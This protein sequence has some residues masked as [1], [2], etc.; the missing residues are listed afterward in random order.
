MRGRDR[1][2]FRSKFDFFC[3]PGVVEVLVLPVKKK[4]P[5]KFGG[6]RVMNHSKTH[7]TANSDIMPI[8]KKVKIP[9]V[10]V[11][12]K[13]EVLT[14]F[15]FPPSAVGFCGVLEA[16]QDMRAGVFTTDLLYSWS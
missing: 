1:L 2:A 9:G 5:L 3:V 10:F 6:V 11:A 16:T 14:L 15:G 4:V 13:V 8:N 7:P 12:D